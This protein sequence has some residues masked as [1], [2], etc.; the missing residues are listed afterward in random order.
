MPQPEICREDLLLGAVDRAGNVQ[1][2]PAVVR[3]SRP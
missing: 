1:R 3:L 2:K